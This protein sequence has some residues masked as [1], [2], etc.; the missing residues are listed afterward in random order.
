MWWYAGSPLPQRKKKQ[1]LLC[2]GCWGEQ[3]WTEGS[4]SVVSLL[5]SVFRQCFLQYVLE[6]L[7]V[8]VQL[9]CPNFVGV[10]S[11]FTV[12]SQRDYRYHEL[13]NGECYC[14][15]HAV[16][17]IN[18]WG[19]GLIW[20]KPSFTPVRVWSSDMKKI[21]CG[22]KLAKRN[23]SP[24][25]KVGQFTVG[26]TTQAQAQTATFSVL[27]YRMMNWQ[28]VWEQLYLNVLPR[29]I[30]CMMTI[31]SD[32]RTAQWEKFICNHQQSPK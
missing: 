6:E 20:V 24:L 3:G 13:F 19:W 14:N 21:V 28:M 10:Q 9:V 15:L 26:Y 32:L 7:I 16:A 25:L 5:T 18:G 11:G 29:T 2:G 12:V 23:G 30:S 4:G 22:S 31:V 8:E 17:A 1:A 27:E